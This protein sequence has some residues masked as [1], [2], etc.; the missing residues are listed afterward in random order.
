[1][2]KAKAKKEEILTIKM[3]RS[4]SPCESGYHRYCTLF[5]KG[6][7]LQAA[8]DGLIADDHDDWAYWLFCEA[9]KRNL[10]E[11]TTARGYRNSGDLNSGN[12]N[13]GDLNSG[14]RNSGDL[15]SGNRN[16]G[17]LNSNDPPVLR[18]FEKDC[19]TDVWDNAYKP[20]FLWFDLTYWVSETEMTDADK[21]ADPNF[22]VRGGQLRKRDFKEAFKLSWDNADKTDRERVRELPNFDA[23]IFF[24]ISGIDLRGK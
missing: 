20:S 11:D 19:P 24:K 2:P 13:S 9:R 6:E 17:Y 14:D 1:M 16:S 7:T 12:R 5:P 15:N 4:W 10:F 18:V 21:A 3:L 8:M 23:E 22:F